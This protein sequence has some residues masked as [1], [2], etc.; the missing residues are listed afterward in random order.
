M[1]SAVRS[2]PN[3]SQ[4][5]IA[6]HAGVARTTVSLVLR[7]GDGLKQET[8]DRVRK[9][10]E[11]LGYRPNRLVSGIKTGK[12]RM[13]GI[14]IPP[15]DYFWARL[16]TGIHDELSR[17]DYIPI[18]LWSPNSGMEMDEER[19]LRQVHRLLDLRI[20]GVILW[21]FFAQMYQ[22]HINEFSSRNLPLVTV[23]Y[24]LAGFQGDSIF[25]DDLVGAREAATHLVSMGHSKVLHFTGPQSE[26]WANMRITGFSSVIG[27]VINVEL[28]LE[29]PWEPLISE[30]LAAHPGITSVFC[31][32]DR[33]ARSL[34]KVARERGVRI[35]E[36]LS[37]VGYG[38]LDFS[39]HLNPPLTTVNSHP[40]RM[41]AR[42]AKAIIERI[43]GQFNE[44]ESRVFKLPVELVVRDSVARI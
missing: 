20:E 14:M 22:R 4:A 15:I 33:F 42:A 34:Y 16:V 11:E 31:S 37:V 13:V 24:N 9:A 32:M 40:Y 8:I 3:P 21:P 28:P 17:N 43:S 38:G 2:I 7:G 29:P 1:S 44:P 39:E 12:S 27:N 19:E 23:D 5:A 30:A 25:S 26:D 41:G 36:D 18:F 35:P 10:A 6:R